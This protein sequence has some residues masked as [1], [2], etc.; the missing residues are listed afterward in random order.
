MISAGRARRWTATIAP[1]L[2]LA[3]PSVWLLLA[4]PPLWRDAD[5]YVQAVFPP[6]AETVLR[7]GPL[8]CALNRIPL[9]LGYLVS[10]TGPAV[11][12]AHFIRHTRLT[13]QGVFILVLFQHLALV[14]GALY[15]I[16]GMAVSTV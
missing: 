16:T 15:L 4:L 3:I 12:L 5:A 2:I 7:H 1:S 13:D 6:S 10:G 11:S 14:L 8:Y 9:W